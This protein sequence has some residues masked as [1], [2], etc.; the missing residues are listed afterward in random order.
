MSDQTGPIDHPGHPSADQ[1]A[2]LVAGLLADGDSAA[3]TAHTESCET[4]RHDL[5]VL[6]GLPSRLADHARATDTAMPAT[7]A[8]GIEAVLAREAQTARVPAPGAPATVLPMRPRSTGGRPAGVRGMRILQAA[9]VVVLVLATGALGFSFLHRGGEAGSASTAAGKASG[10]SSA[11]AGAGGLLLASGRDWS[12]STIRSAA[13]LLTG[14]ELPAVADGNLFSADGGSAGPSVESRPGPDPALA[15]GASASP[16][17][18]TPAASVS[19]QRLADPV[20]LAGCLAALG[21]THPA[22]AVDLARWNGAPAA[23]IVLPSIQGP[24]KV[25]IWVV[26]P[27]CGESGQDHLLDYQ[28]VPRP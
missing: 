7:V 18:P 16:G 11:A 27:S 25:D 20:V 1:L 12:P 14:G 21:T 23:V 17:T 19:I 15:P 2:G 8:A 5:E 3:L 22:I 9:A 28:V 24:T 13:G 10:S 6:S 26:S 4:C